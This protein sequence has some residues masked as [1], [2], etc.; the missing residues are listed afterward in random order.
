MKKIVVTPTKFNHMD[1]L[2]WDDLK[3]LCLDAY[4]AAQGDPYLKALTPMVR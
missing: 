4:S 2:S 3:R 1:E